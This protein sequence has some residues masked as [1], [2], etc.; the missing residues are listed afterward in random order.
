MVKKKKTTKKKSPSSSKKKTTAKSKDT[1]TGY[2][3]LGGARIK[4]K[5][6]KSS[7]EKMIGQHIGYRY[8]VI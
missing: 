4:E 7:R 5:E 2:K 6:I 1:K 3:V 8:D